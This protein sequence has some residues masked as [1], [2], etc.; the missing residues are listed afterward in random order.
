MRVSDDLGP[1]YGFQWRHSGAEY[2]N[3]HADYTGKGVD[4]L[5]HVIEDI[6]TNSTSRRLIICSW[7]PKGW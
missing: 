2:E 4:Q 1:V 3:M 6:K 5:A 7:N